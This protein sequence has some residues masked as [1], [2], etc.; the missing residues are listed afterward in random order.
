MSVIDSKLWV[1]SILVRGGETVWHSRKIR[2]RT[3]NPT[4]TPELTIIFYNYHL[5]IWLA[6]IQGLPDTVLSR[7]NTLFLLT[8]NSFQHDGYHLSHS[9]FIN[10]IQYIQDPD[11]W[12]TSCSK[13][14]WEKW[15]PGPPSGQRIQTGSSNG[16]HG[17]PRSRC[18]QKAYPNKTPARDVN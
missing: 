5:P 4:L 14:F 13:D 9:V 12:I 6:F 10:I 7:F 2:A 16:S 17:F 1:V 15:T 8:H 3:F 11:E 18:P